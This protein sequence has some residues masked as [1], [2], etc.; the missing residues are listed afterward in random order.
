[1]GRCGLCDENV[2]KGDDNMSKFKY[3]SCFSGTGGFEQA[4]NQL[5]GECVMASEIDKYASKAY[6]AIY[7][8]EHLHGDITKINEADVPDHDL[9]TA[10][11]PCQPFSVAG[12]RGGFEDTRGTMFF[13]VARILKEKQPR[14][15]LLE[16]VKG[17]ISH[18]KG[19]TLDTI[20]KTLNDIGYRVDFEVLNSKFFGVPQNRE[21]WF[22]VAV[23]EDLIENEEW[24][25]TKGSKV[26][27]KGKRR[28]MGYEGI[29][30]F[31]FD[32]PEQEEVT[33]KLI[34]VLEPVVDEKYYLPDEKVAELVAKLDEQ[35]TANT[36]KCIHNIYGGFKEDKPRL[37][38]GES[39]TIR[40]SA[41]GGHLPS[42]LEKA[43]QA[44]QAEE[45][46]GCSTRSR[47][48]RGQGEQLEIRKDDV[49]N[50]VTSV[51]KDSMVL[52][53]NVEQFSEGEGVSCCLDANYWK[54]TAPSLVGKGR[55]THIVE[56]EPKYRIRKLTPLECFRLQGFS[57]EV[58]QTI[59]DAGISDSQRYKMAGNAVSVPVIKALGERLLPILGS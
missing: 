22:C 20:V 25:N 14:V 49:G 9:L 58:H 10:G 52:K 13:E 3:V 16:N 33:V 50:T 19:K 45:V 21:R 59:V 39:P 7:G 37:F 38:D 28:I 27:P 48:Y 56:P 54:G 2:T 18:D 57:D 46:K 43:E 31:N 53:G 8:G 40:T 36:P 44:E 11:I 24:V 30:T 17:L 23:R 41:G 55:R 42:V 35:D 47:N 12:K 51:T 26:V 1:M 34:D 15:A 4:L 32:W 6:E 5:G 29:K